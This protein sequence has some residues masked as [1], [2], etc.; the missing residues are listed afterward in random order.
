MFKEI[1]EKK[2]Q[3]KFVALGGVTGHQ[4]AAALFP[5]HRGGCTYLLWLLSFFLFCF[6]FLWVESPT[7]A[8]PTPTATLVCSNA[9]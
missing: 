4:M 6:F 8:P 1:Q 2:K 3:L 5:V 9:S 7:P